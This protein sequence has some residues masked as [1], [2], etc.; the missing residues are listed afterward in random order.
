MIELQ[1][2]GRE[3]FAR[4]IGWIHSPEEL[5]QWAGPAYNYPLDVPQL[6]AN[7]RQ[8][9]GDNPTRKIFKAVDTK[10]QGVIGHIELGN[11]DH[12]SESARISRVLVGDPSYRGKGIGTLIVKR[13]LEIGFEEMGLHRMDLVVFDFNTP[14]IKLYEKLGFVREGRLREIRK[15]G[16]EYW[17][18]YQMSMLE[19]EWRA[20]K[21]RSPFPQ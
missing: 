19:D 8:S 5:L 2:F 1:P 6:E 16:N 21:T 15:M 10:T 20:L 3:D 9:L 18:L 17:S 13:V 12:K 14:A 11:I 7:Y 4:L